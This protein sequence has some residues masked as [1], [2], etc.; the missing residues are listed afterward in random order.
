MLPTISNPTLVVTGTDDV[1]V[2]PANSLII[3]QKI[4]GSWLIQIRGGG[5]GLMYQYPDMFSRITL[6]FL[7]T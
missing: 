6:T 3:A 2:P 1:T 4:P 7:E 5:H